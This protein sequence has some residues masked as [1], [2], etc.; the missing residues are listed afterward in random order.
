MLTP[1]PLIASRTL[2]Q[3]N[4]SPATGRGR[5]PPAKRYRRPRP[6]SIW[7]LGV[8]LFNRAASIRAKPLS[9]IRTRYAGWRLRRATSVVLDALDDLIILNTRPW[10]NNVDV[11]LC[12]IESRKRYWHVARPQHP[13]ISN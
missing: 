3:A 9:L 8:W 10:P 13:T 1:I 2:I 7:M 11:L 5:R 4:K 12:E 6:S